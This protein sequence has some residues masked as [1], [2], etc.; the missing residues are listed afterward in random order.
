M[1]YQDLNDYELLHYVSENIEEANDVVMNKYYPLVLSTVKKMEKYIKNCGLDEND[2]LQ[3][4][5]VGLND[6]ITTFSDREDTIFYTYAKYCVER[7]IVSLI[8]M[9]HRKKHKILNDSLSYDDPTLSYDKLVKDNLNDPLNL[10]IAKDSKYKIENSIRKK[11]TEMEEE[12]FDL[13]ISGVSA[14]EIAEILN[15][16]YKQVDNAIQR[17][18][19]KAKTIFDK[20]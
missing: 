16:D 9:A 18:R 5:M 4:G 7:K 19:N 14:K 12:V 10:I 11:L 1:N 20:Q 6:A 8:V 15:K 17:I 2:L 3:E 13:M